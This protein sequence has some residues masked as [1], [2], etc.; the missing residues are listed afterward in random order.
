M[1]QS[2][3]LFMDTLSFLGTLACILFASFVSLFVPKAPKNVKGK[4]ALVTGGA[5]GLGRLLALKLSKL[6][7]KIVL[8]DVNEQGLRQVA[9]EIEEQGCPGTHHYTCDLS[10][11]EDVYEM[12]KKVQK[13]AGNVDILINNAGIV[14]GKKFLECSDN[15]IEKTFQVNTISHFWTVKSFLPAML[16]NPDGGHIVTIASSAGLCGV[17]SLSDY[18]SSKF[19]AF[20]F[21]ES[22]RQELRKTKVRTTCVCPF[23][24]NTGMF[25]GVKTRFPLLLP[26]L[27]PEYATSKIVDAILTDQEVLVMPRFCWLAPLMRFI[28]PVKAFD[29]VSSFLGLSDAMNEFIGR[30]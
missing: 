21:D 24:I 8:V 10:R 1:P 5:S 2:N 27:D 3:N 11:R 7:C 22:L 12:A 14:T 28:L 15:L 17:T 25:D 18:C 16:T 20:G 30:K 9:K 23:F 19:G 6:G 29:E 4:V 13:E 26:I